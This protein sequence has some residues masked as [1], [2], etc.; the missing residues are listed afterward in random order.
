MI[1]VLVVEDMDITREDIL[2]LIDWEQHGFEL[3][4]SA[5][6]GRIGLE[7]ALRYRPDIV[8]TDIK[9]P[10]MTGLDMMKE[11]REKIPG[12]KF[13]LLTAYEEFEYAKRALEMGTQAFLL[14]YEI[15]SEI[16]LRELNKCV[17]SIRKER[18]VEDMTTR[19]RLDRLL[20]KG[21]YGVQ[22]IQSAA[23][24]ARDSFFPWIGGSILLDIWC[25]CLCEIK[26]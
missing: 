12:T 25:F 20:T 9:M 18:R 21:G 14:K 22:E 2:G 16:L 7:H 3:L 19:A 1:K 17:E 23:T 24:A 6:N 13:I 15:D 5:R 26:K 4:P 8:L 11:I 10:V